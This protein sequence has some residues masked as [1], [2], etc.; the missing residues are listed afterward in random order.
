MSDRY[1]A[2]QPSPEEIE[3]RVSGLGGWFEIDLDCLGS[4][5]NA[6][7]ERTGVEMM[8]VVKN[9]AYLRIEPHARSVS[10]DAGRAVDQLDGVGRGLKTG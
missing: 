5:L 7:R 9:N 10:D 8:P 6:I 1:F 3:Q 4:N 2:M